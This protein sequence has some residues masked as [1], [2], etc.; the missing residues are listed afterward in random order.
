MGR[1]TNRPKVLSKRA[2]VMLCEQGYKCSCGAKLNAKNH[3]D[4][5]TELKC[6]KCALK[7]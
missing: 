2:R 4:F 1:M 5:T 3:F 7:A 6:G